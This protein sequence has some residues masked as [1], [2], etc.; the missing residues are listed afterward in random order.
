MAQITSVTSESLQAQIR[1]LLPSQQGFGEDL[2]ASNVIVPIVDL[3]ST[4]EGSS[5]PSNLQTALAFGSQTSFDVSNT[6][7]EL[8]TTTGFYRITGTATVRN[9]ASGTVP[10]VELFFRDTSGGVNKVFWALNG[11]L[12]SGNASFAADFDY[13]V[14]IAADVQVRCKAET[15]DAKC[16]GSTRQIADISGNLVNPSGFTG[17]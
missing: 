1:T 9:V 16:T 11:G 4:A 6:T 2:Q 3:T 12:S 14:F 17:E 8:I 10:L 13:T 5:L 7:S 15:S